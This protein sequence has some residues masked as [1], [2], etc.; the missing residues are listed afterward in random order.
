M[1]FQD[2]ALH[3]ELYPFRLVGPLLDMRALAAL[4]VDG[5]DL[6]VL[7]L[8]QVQLG[9]QAES[10]RGQGDGTG[11]KVLF[12]IQL[13]SRGQASTAAVH[14]PMG[15]RSIHGI[16]GIRPFALHPFQICQPRAVLVLVD[17]PRGQ[18]RYVAGQLWKRQGQL[19][20]LLFHCSV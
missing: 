5:D 20:L 9:D 8:D 18:Q 16:R 12:L 4:V 1:L 7:G 14:A 6:A 19:A 2:H 15:A 17:H 10:V 3:A 11:V 13:V